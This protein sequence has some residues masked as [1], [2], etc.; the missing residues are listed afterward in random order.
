MLIISREALLEI[1]YFLYNSFEELLFWVVVL[2]Y[3]L[4]QISFEDRKL[5]G[6]ISEVLK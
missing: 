3:P 1:K 5:V 4:L 6:D 2:V